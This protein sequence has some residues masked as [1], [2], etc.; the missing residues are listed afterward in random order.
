MK[1]VHSQGKNVHTELNK[2]LLAHRTTPHCT[3]GKSPAELLFNRKVRCKLPEFV[4]PES[5]AICEPDGLRQ[6][7]RVSKNKGAQYSDKRRHAKISD[8]QEGDS[9]VAAEAR[10]Q[11]D[12]NTVIS[13]RGNEVTIQSSD[14]VQYRRNITFV[15]K[16]VQSPHNA[17]NNQPED[18]TTPDYHDPSLDP[19]ASQHHDITVQ[20][21][22]PLSQEQQRS[23]ETVRHSNRTRTK[24]SYLKDFVCD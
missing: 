3:T 13:K 5:E 20:A 15:K 1:I 4:S 12:N 11:A 21:D 10:K 14:G 9:F 17:D 24:P 23:E 18:D 22:D 6:R 8:I 19:Q 7:D 2:F 16:Y